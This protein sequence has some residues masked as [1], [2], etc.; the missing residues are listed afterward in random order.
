MTEA[1]GTYIYRNKDIQSIMRGPRFPIII[2]FL[3]CVMADNKCIL[4]QL[5]E[6]A[7]R[8]CAVDIEVEGLDGC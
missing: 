7:F 5:F 3:C 8:G 6:E 4:W 1:G 2:P